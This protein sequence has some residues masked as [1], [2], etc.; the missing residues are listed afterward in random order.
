MKIV[1]LTPGSGYTSQP[2]LT[3]A[4]PTGINGITASVNAGKAEISGIAAILFQLESGSRG[5]DISSNM[6]LSGS[7][8]LVTNV[9]TGSSANQRYVTV[10]P[11]PPSITTGDNVYFHQLSNIST[12]GLVMEYGGSGVT[13]NALPK[14]GGVPNRTKEI[15]EYAPGRVFYSTVD[16]IGNLKIG[17]FFAVNQLTGEVT[18]DANQ[19]NLSGLSAIGP[20]KRNGVGVGVVLNEVSNNATLLN[21]QG[22]TGEDTVPTQFAVKGYIDIRDGRLN[23]LEAFTASISGTNAFTA[24]TKT[25]LTNL[26]S[27][28]ASVNISVAALNATSAS[29]NSYTASLRNA[30]TASGVNVTFNG[31]TTIKGNLFVQGTQ[32]VV[33]STTINLA[34]NILVL[35]AAGTSDGGLVVRDATGG[36]TTSGSLLWDVTNDY[37]KAGALGAESKLL[38]EGGD[39]VISSSA[40]LTDLNTFTGSANTRLTNLESTT[41]SLETRATTLAT[42]TGSVNTRLTEVGVVTGSL[43]TS[44]SNA[45]I[46]VANLNAASSS[47]E[48]KGRGI[49]SG[50]SQID[51]TSTTGYSTFSG[52]IATSVSASNARITTLETLIDGGTY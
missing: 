26:E 47:Y 20:F 8:Y 45:T 29:L 21:A 34:D 25:R 38:R 31:D 39:G 5:I 6:I 51:I 3:I 33:D 7:N 22:I 40:Q 27:T 14:F 44:Q 24:S 4:A 37:W 35:N 23:N 42:H 15:I 48:T 17:D 46:S 16:N 30:F 32:T 52:S 10:Y 28:S 12:G 41:S 43:I 13:Y 2:T 19:F 36:S 49:V 9:A 1:I 18:I 50:S 11:A